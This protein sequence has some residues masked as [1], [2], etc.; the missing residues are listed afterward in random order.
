MLSF[1]AEG[2]V[3]DDGR[4]EEASVV[5]IDLPSFLS[6]PLLM[7]FV[8]VLLYVRTL[9]ARLLL[10]NR[11]ASDLVSTTASMIVKLR[12]SAAPILAGRFIAMNNR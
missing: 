7:P 1:V 6:I 4:T 2:E 9:V 10:V 3:V 12:K 11:K 5:T 8:T